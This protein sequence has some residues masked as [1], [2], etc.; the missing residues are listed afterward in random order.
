[1][2][3]RVNIHTTFT[4]MHNPV[5]EHSDI[6][7]SKIEESRCKQ[8]LAILGA[9][10]LSSQPRVAVTSC[11][12]YKVIRDIESIDHLCINPIHRIGFIHK[13]SIDS[14]MLK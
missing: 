9:Q 12:V 4:V 6:V 11:F 5:F 2:F 8:T 1:M 3:P 13:R 7:F 14:R 10:V